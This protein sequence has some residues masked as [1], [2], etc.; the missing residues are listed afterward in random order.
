[1][2]LS[3]TVELQRKKDVK[4]LKV[5]DFSLKHKFTPWSVSHVV[6]FIHCRFLGGEQQNKEASGT[7]QQGQEASK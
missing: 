2:N 5:T 7:G 1:M 4:D 6:A 3:Y